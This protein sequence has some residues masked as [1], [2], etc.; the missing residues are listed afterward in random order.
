MFGLFGP[1]PKFKL[2][3]NMEVELELESPEGFRSYF[4]KILDT[5]RKKAAFATPKVGKRY[6]PINKDD[7]IKMICV[8]EDTLFEVNIKVTQA[9]EQE[10]A[11]MVS[12]NETRFD[13]LLKKFDKKQP[14]VIDAEVPLDFRAIT[15]SHMQRGS[16]SQVTKEHV[17]MITNLPVPSGTDLKLEF[18]IPESPIIEAEGISAKSEPV[19]EETRRSKTRIEFKDKI[20]ES[21]VFDRATTYTIHYLRRVERRKAAEEEKKAAEAGGAKNGK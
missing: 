4:T 13:T 3:K 11:A 6:L 15:T 19:D 14:V 2:T 20:K 17:D 9:M 7:I 16:T 8:I 5:S 10:F 18:R 12:K 1:K 21:D